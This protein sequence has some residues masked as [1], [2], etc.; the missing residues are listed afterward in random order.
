MRARIL[1]PLALVLAPLPAMAGAQD[2]RASLSYEDNVTINIACHDAIEKGDQS[3][4]KAQV[5]ALAQ[6]PSPDRT[7]L[8][9][10][11]ARAIEEDCAYLRQKGVAQ[12]NDCLTK[13]VAAA[14]PEPAAADDED[15]AP[16]KLVVKTLI[17]AKPE[18]PAPQSTL[19][20]PSAVL[21]SSP[22]PVSRP[23][24]S[25]AALYKLL[26][27]SIFVVAAASSA[28]DARAR[29]ISQG[30]AVAVTEHLLLTNCHVVN[31]RPV[32]ALV[33]DDSVWHAKLVAAD[34]KDDRCVLEAEGT[35]LTPV[36]GI[37]P[38]DDIAVGEQVFAIGAPHELERTMTDGLVSGRRKMGGRNMI[39]TSAPVSR[40]S[41]GG[42][43][44]DTRGNLLGITTLG[45]LA[46]WQNLNFAVAAGDYYN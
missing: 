23:P 29:Q 4:V 36:P 45:S 13:A 34:V 35:D 5:A 2:E 25:P 19:P 10:A 30:S 44:F 9:A 3:C 6:H 42:G 38:F 33:Q 22:G 11:R 12:Y 31:G 14:P 28:G 39:Q 37:R 40:G 26:Q 20:P 27:K 8:S 7:G 41:S 32:I 46:G 21:H 18:A 1:F 15:D 43:L 17:S 24:L 16:T